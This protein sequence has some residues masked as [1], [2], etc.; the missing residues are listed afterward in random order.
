MFVLVC[1]RNTHTI[2]KKWGC[3][4]FELITFTLLFSMLLEEEAHSCV[5]LLCLYNY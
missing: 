2:Y 1:H 5:K 4:P 3:A